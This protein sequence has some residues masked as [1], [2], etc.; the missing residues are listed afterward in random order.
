MFFF[1]GVRVSKEEFAL[2]EAN[3]KCPSVLTPSLRLKAEWLGKFCR[4][5]CRVEQAVG[6]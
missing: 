2:L 1:Y 3:D 4:D 5:F 6:A